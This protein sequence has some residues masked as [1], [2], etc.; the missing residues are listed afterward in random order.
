MPAMMIH[1]VLSA[2]RNG[3]CREVIVDIRRACVFRHATEETVGT[4]APARA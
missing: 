3:T 2:E 1:H 4:P